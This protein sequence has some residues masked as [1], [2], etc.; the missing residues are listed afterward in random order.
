VAIGRPSDACSILCHVTNKYEWKNFISQD[1][2]VNES[3][4]I[5]KYLQ[6][7]GQKLESVQGI[8]PIFD[9]KSMCNDHYRLIAKL[10]NEISGTELYQVISKNVGQDKHKILL[11]T[12]YFF[13][14]PEVYLQRLHPQLMQELVELRKNCS[15][16]L[17]TLHEEI[18][19]LSQQISQIEEVCDDCHQSHRKVK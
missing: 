15:P 19:L 12:L 11:L 10:L 5:N 2:I 13:S 6:T 16:S 7:V 8:V 14:V 9:E 18:N 1:Q 17:Y 3:T 4:E